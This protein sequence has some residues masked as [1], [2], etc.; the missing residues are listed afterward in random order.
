MYLKKSKA[1]CN[2]HSDRSGESLSSPP[3][4]GGVGVVAVVFDPIIRVANNGNSLSLPLGKREMT[5]DLTHNN[6]SV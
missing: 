6:K 3:F 1:W 2:C 5:S 4:Q